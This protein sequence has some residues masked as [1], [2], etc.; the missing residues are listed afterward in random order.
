VFDLI[1]LVLFLLFLL[2]SSPILL[3]DRAPDDS[4]GRSGH[5]QA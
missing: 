2:L 3:S 1:G 4:V 5:R